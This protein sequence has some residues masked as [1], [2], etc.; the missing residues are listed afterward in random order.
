MWIMEFGTSFEWQLGFWDIDDI[1][2]FLL[3]GVES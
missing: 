2:V 3:T 1:L